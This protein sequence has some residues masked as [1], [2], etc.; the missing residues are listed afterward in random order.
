[1]LFLIFI[2]GIL[3]LFIYISSLASN[4]QIKFSPWF[5]IKWNT[6]VTTS[7]LIIIMFDK[8]YFITWFKNND[9]IEFFNWQNLAQENRLI[10]SKIYD[11]PNNFIIILLITYLLLTLIVVVK[12][13]RTFIGPLRPK[14]YY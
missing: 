5:F 4:E 2:G 6:I 9:T 1:M 12:I 10:L 14:H 13:T 11:T 8:S 7:L 3:I